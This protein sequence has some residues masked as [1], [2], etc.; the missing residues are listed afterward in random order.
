MKKRNSNGVP[1]PRKLTLLI[2]STL[3]VMAGAM[4]AP[5]LPAI[6]AHFAD[7]PNAGDLTRLVLTIPALFIVL[8]SPLAGWLADRTGRKPLLLAA[9]LLY[10]VTGTAG[11]FLE[12][13]GPLLVSRSLLGVAVAGVMTT[14]TTLIGDYFVDK[15]RAH[16][17]G[18]QAAWMGIGG[19]VFQIT[20]GQLAEI[21]WRT[22]FLLYLGAIILVPAII[23]FLVEPKKQ[24]E[25]SDALEEF[26]DN[27]WRYLIITLYGLTLIGSTAFF[28][29][30]TQLPFYLQML[31]VLEPNRIGLAIATMT[32]GSVVASILY[33]RVRG[34]ADTNLVTAL[35]FGGMAIGYFMVAGVSSYQGVLLSMI[36]AGLGKGLLIPHMS[37][38]VLIVAPE[39]LRGRLIGGLMASFFLGQFLSPFFTQPSSRLIGLPATFFGAAV[40]LAVITLVHVVLATRKRQSSVPA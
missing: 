5:S 3:T 11:Y 2:A 35:S 39:H 31:G 40:I 22:P 8:C 36:V 32:G 30:P 1:W 25:E 6:E 20:G 18:L 13:I 4:I 28:M 15:A 7:V 34:R 16:F 38:F 24:P 23:F 37:L 9:T 14:A 27:S 10:V 17:M 29:V 33:Q 26:E 19:I 12:S 21:H